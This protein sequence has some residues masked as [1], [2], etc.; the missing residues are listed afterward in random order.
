MIKRCWLFP[1]CACGVSLA[2]RLADEGQKM[3]IFRNRDGSLKRVPT[4][5]VLTFAVVEE[6]APDQ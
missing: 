6:V 5:E 4:S 2:N 3:I 1:H